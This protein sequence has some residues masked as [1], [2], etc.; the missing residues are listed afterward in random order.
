M[1]KNFHYYINYKI[2]KFSGFTEKQ[3]YQISYSAQFVDDNTK[4]FQVYNYCNQLIYTN[5]ISQ[6]YNIALP[7]QELIK[8]YAC[9]HFLPG[10][11][12]KL[13]SS[14]KQSDASATITTANSKLA[15]SILQ[16]ALK[17]K[18][19]YLIGIASHAYADTWAHQNFTAINHGINAKPG[20]IYNLIPNYGHADFLHSPDIINCCWEDERLINPKV[21][22]TQRFIDAARNLFAEYATFNCI[23]NI[24]N[25]TQILLHKINDLK[26]IKNEIY[27]YNECEWEKDAFFYC[28][29]ESKF[30]EHYNFKE[31]DWFGFQ[32]AVKTY[33][34]VV[35]RKIKEL[36]KEHLTNDDN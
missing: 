11:Y 24:E 8:I 6:T 20:L 32:E 21:S 23:K 7:E 15:R 19:Y 36:F 9:F 27:P 25:K 2:A 31:S 16:F 13:D 3:S 1:D 35:W 12:N 17:S 22:N 29:Y 26:S 30:I 10:D 4:Q 14:F 18:N 28:D 33:K 34:Q 5:E